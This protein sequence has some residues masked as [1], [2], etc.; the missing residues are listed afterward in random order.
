[1]SPNNLDAFFDAYETIVSI[2]ENH[3]KILL[4]RYRE[5]IR[6]AVEVIRSASEDRRIIHIVGT[7][8]SKLAG[9]ILGE[10]L[11]NLGYNVSIIGDTLSKPVKRGDV[12][13]AISSSGWTN[14]TLYAV[15]Q[16]LK[17]GAKIIGLTA[18]VGS[19]LYRLADI[20]ILLPGK[21]RIDETPYIIRQILGKHKTP[22]TPMGTISEINAILLGVGIT[23]MLRNGVK[24]ISA[25]REP[26][27][28]I[29]KEAKSNLK[30]LRE[31]VSDITSF[32]EEVSDGVK[33]H[34]RKYYL[35]G[36]GICDKVSKMI[37]M[38]YQHLSINVQPINWWRFRRENDVLIAISGSGENPFLLL[39]AKEAKRSNMKVLVLTANDESTLA[40]L[41]DIAIFFKDISLRED[42][43][44]LKIGEETKIFLPRLQIFLIVK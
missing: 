7:G 4:S 39:Y 17:I 34:E 3:L 19:K 6:R 18:T 11:S 24:D 8:R 33:R 5:D 40:N 15:E 38:R 35:I 36:L 28:R 9:E 12:V 13:I 14:T 26:I 32:I 23:S 10:L 42:Y 43:I 29:L 27:L 44:K 30:Q 1:M 21:P 20:N 22:L 37:A 25:F 31:Y 16:S 2:S 41:A